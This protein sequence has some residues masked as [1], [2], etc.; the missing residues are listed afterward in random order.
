MPQYIDMSTRKKYG[1]NFE[2]VRNRE[3]DY[4]IRQVD[5]PSVVDYEPEQ[6]DINLSIF[7]R[8]KSS[9]PAVAWQLG[10]IAGWDLEP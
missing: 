8:L 3:E 9:Q 10:Q 6:T 2:L 1:N 4:R 5:K 7:E